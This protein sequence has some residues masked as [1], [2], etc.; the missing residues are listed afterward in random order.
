[1]SSAPSSSTLLGWARVLI[2]K[3]RLE[4]ASGTI[5][6]FENVRF[7]KGAPG[8]SICAVLN[9]RFCAAAFGRRLR[10]RS[11]DGML[12]TGVLGA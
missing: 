9:C 8:V 1:M 4:S 3:H 5:E 2:G 7:R 6:W 10:N 11:S 12:S